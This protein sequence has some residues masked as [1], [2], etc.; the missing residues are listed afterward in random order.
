VAHDLHLVM[1]IRFKGSAVEQRLEK[2]E[3]DH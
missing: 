3:F 2:A 1:P